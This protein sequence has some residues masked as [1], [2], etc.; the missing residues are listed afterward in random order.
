[1]I[2]INQVH[3]WP[4]RSNLIPGIQ[5]NLNALYGVDIQLHSVLIL[6]DWWEVF[7]TSLG[8]I[9]VVV[10]S[11]GP[12]RGLRGVGTE[13]GAASTGP[14][15]PSVNML[16]GLWLHTELSTRPISTSSWS[17]YTESRWLGKVPQQSLLNLKYYTSLHYSIKYIIYLFYLNL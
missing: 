3:S 5:R 13:F 10:G 12:A 16:M 7:Q 1:M 17:K 8:K 11:S 15:S 2:G 4:G 6:T 9:Y 14:E